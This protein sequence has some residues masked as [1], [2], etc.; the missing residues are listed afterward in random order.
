MLIIIVLLVQSYRTCYIWNWSRIICLLSHIV[1]FW[2]CS[3]LS[4]ERA[5]NKLNTSNMHA[6]N[7]TQYNPSTHTHTHT[8][9]SQHFRYLL[10][11]NSLKTCADCLVLYIFR[12]NHFTLFFHF[13]F[14]SFFSSVW[15]IDE[16]IDAKDFFCI[17]TSM[18]NCQWQKFHSFSG[19]S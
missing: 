16:G 5:K 9:S 8:K 10:T 7:M 13:P 14:A 4:E 12:S 1:L 3:Q 18:L 19:F 2:M 15:R 11:L 6:L 17:T